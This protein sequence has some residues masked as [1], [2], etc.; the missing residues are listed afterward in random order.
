MVFI[1]RASLNRRAD[2]FEQSVKHLAGT[3]GVTSASAAVYPLLSGFSGIGTGS[4]TLAACTTDF[5]PAD[6]RERTV[7]INQVTPHFFETMRLSVLAGK[8][9]DWSDRPKPGGLPV[10]IVRRKE[11]LLRRSG[12]HGT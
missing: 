7:G 1:E 9:F 3:P 6:P 11:L 5:N 10:A 12:A 4:D 2:F 8:D